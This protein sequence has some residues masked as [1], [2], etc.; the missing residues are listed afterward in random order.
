ME[1]ASSNNGDLQLAEMLMEMKSSQE[2]IT[3]HDANIAAADANDASAFDGVEQNTNNKNGEY[4]KSNGYAGN[5]ISVKARAPEKDHFG[6]CYEALQRA[7]AEAGRQSEVQPK[8]PAIHKHKG[9]RM[10]RKRRKSGQWSGPPAPAADHLGAVRNQLNAQS[11]RKLGNFLCKQ[12]AKQW[13]LREFF[14]SLP[15][16]D[17]QQQ[18]HSDDLHDFLCHTAAPGNGASRLPRACLALLRSE[19]RSVSAHSRTL[20]GDSFALHQV[21]NCF[22]KRSR[23]E[24]TTKSDSEDEKPQRKRPRMRGL[25]KRL[26]RDHGVGAQAVSKKL[27]DSESLSAYIGRRCV[28]IHPQSGA[29]RRG[30]ALSL[31]EQSTQLLVQFEDPCAGVEP[32]SIDDIALSPD[33][34]KRSY[35]RRDSFQEHLTELRPP[36]QL[37]RCAALLDKKERVVHE[38][39]S[40]NAAAEKTREIGEDVSVEMKKQYSQLLLELQNL[41]Q[42]LDRGLRDLRASDMITAQQTLA[43]SIKGGS[44][45]AP[46]LRALAGS[47]LAVCEPNI[48][49]GRARAIG[50]VIRAAVP[51]GAVS[52][53]RLDEAEH[54]L[55]RLESAI[56]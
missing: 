45:L 18:R 27:Q 31:A 33:D 29:P 8:F 42:M 10:P 52:S 3:G 37:I 56:G 47:L 43:T 46:L 5:Q 50:K 25:T 24:A 32:V 38:L 17:Q 55:Q 4:R 49:S 51:E 22:R 6:M 26:L 39:G 34:C 9:R 11:L 36:P 28:A 14:D 54:L 23:N 19:Q 41:D 30:Q 2:E 7:H 40:M 20:N 53:E 48:G 16:P 35:A 1:H 13:A 15:L 21:N 12:R 44:E